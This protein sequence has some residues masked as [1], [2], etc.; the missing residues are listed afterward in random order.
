MII[1]AHRGYSEKYPENTMIAFEKAIEFGAKAI[2]CDVQLTKDNKLVVTH[3]E[4]IK[5]C[6][7]IDGMV[8]DFSLEELKRFDFSYKDKFKDANFESIPELK[9]LL[10]LCKN[11]DILLNIELKNSEIFYENLEELTLNE[12]EKY[13][14]PELILYSSFNHESVEKLINMG[15]SA[16]PLLS[17]EKSNLTEFLSVMKAKGV[18]PGLD[19]LNEVMENQIKALKQLGYFINIYTINDIET[20]KELKALNVDGIFTDKCFDMLEALK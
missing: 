8:K 11:N 15:V 12:V 20:A 17:E 10:I 4:N 2:E 16:V 14:N 19:V 3:D 1:F 7:G 9:D 5:R 13:A 6:T 18:H